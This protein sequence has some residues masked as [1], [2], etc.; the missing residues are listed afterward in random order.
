[1]TCA[2]FHTMILAQQDLT[3]RII[4]ECIKHKN[5]CGR[6]AIW[7]QWLAASSTPEQR[8]NAMEQLKRDRP[9]IERLLY[10]HRSN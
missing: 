9:E 10:P 4:V 7:V 3:L 6:C 5:E 1:M 2:E 8:E